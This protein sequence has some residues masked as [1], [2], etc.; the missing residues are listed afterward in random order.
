MSEADGIVMPIGGICRKRVQ[1]PHGHAAVI[2]DE[3]RIY[4][5]GA[6]LPW[7]GAESRVICQSED[8]AA[9][10]LRKKTSSLREKWRT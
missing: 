2:R 3:I 10:P 7:E 5:T 4:A 6:L 9:G 8:G 1:I